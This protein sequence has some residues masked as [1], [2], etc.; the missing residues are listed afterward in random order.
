MPQSTQHTA[1]TLKV[2]ARWRPPTEAEAADGEICYRTIPEITGLSTITTIPEEDSVKIRP[3]G[4]IPETPWTSAP[5]FS[6]VL[7]PDQ[8]N[9]T[10]FETVVKPSIPQ[11]MEGANCSFF[12]YGHSGSGK[13]H[14]IVGYDHHDSQ[15]LGLSLAAARD[16]FRAIH[17]LNDSNKCS[18]Q[19]PLGIGLSVFEMRNKVAVDLLNNGQECAIK[20]GYDGK[21][22]IR[23]QPE[24]LEGGE[25]RVNFIAKKPH[26]TFET[27][28]KDL[29]EALSLRSVGSSHVHDQSSRSHAIIEFEIINQVLIDARSSIL[30]AKAKA[31]PMGK[32]QDDLQYKLSEMRKKKLGAFH[33]VDPAIMALD[34]NDTMDRLVDLKKQ[35]SRLQSQVAAAEQNAD[36]ILKRAH[37]PCLGAKLVFV[38]LAGAEYHKFTAEKADAFQQS[39]QEKQEG[40]QINFDVMASK[41]VMRAWSTNQPWIPFRSSPL[42]M[43]LREYFVGQK[44]GITAMIVNLSPAKERYTAT[45][46]SL[47]YGSLVG[48]PKLK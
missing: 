24:M 31:V 15:E 45:L 17:S 3:W 48:A 18:S 13:T 36:D 44:K 39:H 9:A 23:G 21:V 33:S 40:C 12:A 8:D 14:T 35:V 42:T 19:G 27:L 6:A 1:G 28:E 38:D 22:H 30:D 41:E 4:I 29:L 2:F 26:W 5:A 43:V 46:D 20:E 37:P 10:V 16:L 32:E 34:V 7:T 25:V 11:V 47:R